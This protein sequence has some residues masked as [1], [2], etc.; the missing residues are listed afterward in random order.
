MFGTGEGEVMAARVAGKRRSA[1]WP[2]PIDWAEARN[3]MTFE[4][5]DG[6]HDLCEWL[7]AGIKGLVGG[8][9]CGSARSGDR[10]AISTSDTRE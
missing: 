1:P 10:V 9:L 5:Y 8:R 4:T 2:A 6:L 3:A 7:D